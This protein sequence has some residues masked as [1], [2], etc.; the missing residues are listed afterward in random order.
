MHSISYFISPSD[1][2][3]SIGTAQPPQTVDTRNSPGK[4]A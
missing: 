4:V 3:N 2:W 1:F